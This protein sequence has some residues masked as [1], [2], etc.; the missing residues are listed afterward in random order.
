MRLF[1]NRIFQIVLIVLVL[2]FL[3][4]PSLT[5]FKEY[6]QELTY[7]TR[8]VVFKRNFNGLIFSIYQKQ[9]FTIDDEEQIN[10]EPPIKY[11]GFCMNFFRL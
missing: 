10:P 7:K 6:S 5:N 4:N 1:K 11:F 3:L 9:V 8:K 2:L